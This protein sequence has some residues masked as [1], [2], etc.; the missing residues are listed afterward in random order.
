MALALSDNPRLFFNRHL[1]WL[2]FNGRVLDEAHDSSNPLL[3]RV[4]FLAI[5]ASNLDEY[6]EVRLAALMQQ[7]EHG[8]R[9]LSADG[10]TPDQSLAELTAKIQAFVDEQY[11]C[12]R[13]EL[14]PAL[15][16]EAVRVLGRGELRPEARDYI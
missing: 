6:V 11:E 15:H 7:A 3:E 16:E 14:Q 2:Q 8:N 1:S 13:D 9:E 12:W 10:R 5:T 4:K